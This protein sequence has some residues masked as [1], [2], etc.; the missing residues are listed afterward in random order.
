VEGCLDFKAM[1]SVSASKFGS[2]AESNFEPQERFLDEINS[3]EGIT[4]VETQTYTLMS[5]L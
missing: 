2:W 3:I 4:N 5:M 1:I